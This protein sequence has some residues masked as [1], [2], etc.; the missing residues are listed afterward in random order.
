MSARERR[1]QHAD[2]IY[3]FSVLRAQYISTVDFHHHSPPLTEHDIKHLMAF[4]DYYVK[5]LLFCY[6]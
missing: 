5:L 4:A 1:M 2:K 3:A 6:I